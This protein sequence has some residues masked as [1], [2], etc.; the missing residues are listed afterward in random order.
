MVRPAPNSAPVLPPAVH[1]SMVR[2]AQSILASSPAV[3][4]GQQSKPTKTK[5]DK[6]FGNIPVAV[7][8]PCDSPS[9]I[10]SLMSEASLSSR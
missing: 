7:A 8:I 5:I 6:D 9:L 1:V 4:V 2:P 3:N 10:L